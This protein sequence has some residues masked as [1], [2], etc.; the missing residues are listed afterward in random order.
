MEGSLEVARK[1][2]LVRVEASSQNLL[3]DLCM[4]YDRPGAEE[5]AL[6]GLAVAR[7]QGARAREVDMLGNLDVRADA[8]RALGRGLPARGGGSGIHRR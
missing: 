6:A 4:I 8:R 5:H 2:D 7:R 3:T 1:H